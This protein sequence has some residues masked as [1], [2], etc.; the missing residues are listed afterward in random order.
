MKAMTTSPTSPTIAVL[1]LGAMG[2]ALASTLDQAGCSVIG[3]NRT[4]RTLTE[5]GLDHS[6]MTIAEDPRDAVAGADMVVVCLRDHDVSR[7]VIDLCAGPLRGRLVVNVSTGTPAETAESA[8]RASALGI[9]YVSAAVMVPTMLVGTEHSVVLYA[10][11]ADDLGELQPLLTALGGVNDLVGED[12]AVPAVLDLA[13]LDVYFA[14]MHAFLHSAVVASAH[15]I[16][17]L[18][19]LPYAEGIVDTLKATLPDLASA[20][21]GRTYDRGE[22][23]LDMCLAFLEKIVATSAEVGVDPG[24]SATVRDASRHAM[25]QVPGTTDWDVV[26]EAF[27]RQREAGRVAAS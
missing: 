14:G 11:S 1:G 16:D 2:T 25:K 24:P 9:R 7:A 4:L 13:M 15:G 26:A 6:R 10:G 20:V 5:L 21:Q 18:R 22:A 12:H 3:W 17:P 23:R 8:R 19:Y 27:L